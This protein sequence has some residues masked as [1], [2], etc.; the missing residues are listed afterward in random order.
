MEESLA[1]AQRFLLELS[2]EEKTRL[3]NDLLAIKD[4]Y[5]C[6]K[7][8]S[9]YKFRKIHR[10]SIRS[11][12]CRKRTL[13]YSTKNSHELVIEHIHEQKLFKHHYRIQ[14][15]Y[16]HQEFGYTFVEALLQLLHTQHFNFSNHIAYA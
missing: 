6:L 2:E 12:E 10:A 4:V 16:D 13:R 3:Y 14:V 15:T 5:S 7:D 8:A 9:F 1:Y 11:N